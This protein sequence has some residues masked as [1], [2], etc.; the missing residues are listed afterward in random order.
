MK[1]ED[2]DFELKAYKKYRLR[3][4]VAQGSITQ[5]QANQLWRQYLKLFK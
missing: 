2:A 3:M 4:L 5:E 1:I